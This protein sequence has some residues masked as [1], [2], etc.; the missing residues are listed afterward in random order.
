MQDQVSHAEIYRELGALQ[1]KMDSLIL[2]ITR[3][4][5]DQGTI[6]DR[7]GKLENR[8]AQVVI[9]AVVAG[10]VMP[11]VAGRIFGPPSHSAPAHAGRT[12]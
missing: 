8:M 10:L 4:E 3:S 9:V 1:G 11:I 7:L 12:R 2:Q 6:F 5:R